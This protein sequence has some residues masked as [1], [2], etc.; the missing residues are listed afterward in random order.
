MKLPSIQEILH[1][2]VWTL[3]RFPLVLV[4]AMAG[5]IAAL[6][7]IEYEATGGADGAF[8]VLYAALLGVPMLIGIIL[9][10]EKRRWSMTLKLGLQLAGLTML[11]VYA[12]TLP[13]NLSHAPN[14]HV[15][16]Q[17]MLAVG[18]HLFVAVAPWLGR[19]ETNGFWQY[20]KTLFLRACIAALFTGVLFAGLAIALAA[21]EN[22]FEL[23]I[24][25]ERYGQL[26]ALLVGMFATWFFLAGVPEDLDALDAVEEYPKGL[27]IFAQYVLMPLVIVYFIILAAYAGKIVLA[28]DWPYGWVSRLILGFSVAGMFSLLLLWPIR[29]R[30]DSRWILGAI[31]WF[32]LVLAPLLVMYFLA[33]L[34][35]L[36]EYGLTENRYLG[37]VTGIWLAIMV[38]YFLFSRHKS[39]KIIPLT[40]GVLAFVLSVGPWG[41]FAVSERS[42]VG[43]LRTLLER[44]GLLTDGRLAARDTSAAGISATGT[45]A[46]DTSAAGISAQVKFEDAREISAVIDYLREMHGYEEIRS[47]FSGKADGDSLRLRGEWRSSAEITRM[48]GVEYSAGWRGEMGGREIYNAD[49]N[50]GLVIAGYDRMLPG[51]FIGAGDQPPGQE[52]IRFLASGK[53]VLADEAGDIRY[54]L[55]S[56]LDTLTFTYAPGGRN[57]ET[58]RVPL[59]PVAD[60]LRARYHRMGA[61]GIPPE[62][63]AVE[64]AGELLRVKVYCLMLRFEKDDGRLRI[65][66]LR[67]RVLYGIRPAPS[68]Q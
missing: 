17:F 32:H 57:G 38:G 59:R 33:V 44:N 46:A 13:G 37:I 48:M 26:W 16:R 43:R 58:L 67:L 27:K 39:P 1:G 66:N 47:W 28:W 62:F 29:N 52:E 11:A 5:T 30:E 23:Q 35:R 41:V 63:T 40:L 10:G 56:T 45:S 34:R 7:L 31:R 22:L 49:E 12:W 25:G 64:A 18:V 50:D 21:V 61:E 3:R 53:A 14:V 68:G 55:N 20:N 24:P 60:S 19:G 9:M 8:R 15:I 42:Q 6:V 4:V 54:S 65:A 2:A 36:S 51:R